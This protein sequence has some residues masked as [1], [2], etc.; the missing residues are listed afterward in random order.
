MPS[1]FEKI[2]FMCLNDGCKVKGR[3]IIAFTKHFSSCKKTGL[4]SKAQIAA[5]RRLFDK[6]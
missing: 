2:R 6:P 5:A 3:K 4:K 1:E